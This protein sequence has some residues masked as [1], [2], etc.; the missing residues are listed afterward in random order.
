MRVTIKDIEKV[1]RVKYI[2]NHETVKPFI[3]DDSFNEEEYYDPT[4]HIKNPSV[5]FLMPEDG[6]LFTYYPMNLITY[7]VHVQALPESRGEMFMEAARQA[8]FYMFGNTQ[9]RK[10]V[11]FV[12]TKNEAVLKFAMKFGFNI[13]GTLKNSVL[14]KGK[15]YD[16]IIIDITKGIWK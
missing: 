8:T 6:T 15:E 4:A 14:Y 12:P 13:V 3:T 5:Y 7:R 16:Q 1:E 11:G 9:C 2:L 10:I